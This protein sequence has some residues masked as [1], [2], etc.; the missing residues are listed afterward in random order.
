MERTQTTQ[1]HQRIGDQA[2]IRD[3]LFCLTFIYVIFLVLIIVYVLLVEEKRSQY[4]PVDFEA[5]IL[6]CYVMTFVCKELLYFKYI[7]GEH[8]RKQ[9][10]NEVKSN[11]QRSTHWIIMTLDML[12]FALIC[13]GFNWVE[14]RR[15]L[16]MRLI[17]IF[18]VAFLIV[19]I[20]QLTKQ[21]AMWL[22]R[23]R[24]V[25]VV[26]PRDD[27]V[28]QVIWPGAGQLAQKPTRQNSFGQVAKLFWSTR[29]MSLVNSPNSFGQLAKIIILWKSFI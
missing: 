17:E 23:R 21:A 5:C 18:V 13:F 8:V 10:E 6:F 24:H 28:M 20:Y 27:H 29:Q 22:L 12:C 14:T 3:F 2:L 25:A 26:I 7:D 4:F 11:V 15:V 16:M 19:F 9:L 1:T